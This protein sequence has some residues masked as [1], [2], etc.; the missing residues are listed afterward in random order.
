M[1]SVG[2]MECPI[3]TSSA[4]ITVVVTAAAHTIFPLADGISDAEAESEESK[5][6]NKGGWHPG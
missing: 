5:Q 1:T 4:S 3:Q 2:S 6:D